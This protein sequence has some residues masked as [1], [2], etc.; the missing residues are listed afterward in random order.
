MTA[1]ELQ[2]HLTEAR[3]LLLA[4]EFGRALPRYEKLTRQHPGDAVLW[5]EYGNAAS[6]LGQ[7]DLADQLWQKALGLA[8]NNAELIGMIGHQYQG[9]RRP[10]KAGACFARAA[11][12][13]PRGINPRISLAVL[14][15]KRHRLDEARAAVNECLAIDS[16]DD[17]ARY[18]SAVLDRR[19]GKVESAETRLRDLIKSSPRHPFVQYACRYELAQ[20][21][22]RN[23]DFDGAMRLLGEAKQIVRGLTDTE[24]LLKGYDKG[25]ESAR[26]FTLSFPKTILRTWAQYFPERKRET[27]A[28]LAFLGGHPRSGTTLLEQVLDS[29]PEVAALDEPT[30]FL[31]VLQPE[32]HKSKELSSARLNT[33]RRLYTAA[34]LR[35]AGPTA[36]G[37]L[38]LDKNPS[39]TARL[40]LWLRV[41]PELRVIIALRDPRDVILSCY[42]QNIALN[43][44]NVNFLSFERLAKH[45]SD[46]MDI[47]LA[48]REWEGFEWLETRY[49]DIVAGLEKEGR[50]VTEFLGLA[51]HDEQAHFY[52]KSRSRQLYSPTYQ[53]V[54]RPVY[55]RSV[56]RWRSYEKYL[57]PILPALEPYCRTFGYC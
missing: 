26:R 22:D 41:F 55:S 18:F 5:A 21:L 49:E 35:E 31:D 33:L 29:H 11:G 1:S 50:R 39:P 8:G 32:F 25:A 46:L 9:M 20:I 16:N 37:K 51:W 47:W 42:F 44:T 27:P 23:N 45:Y 53:D 36:A 7:V 4:R 3:Q 6:G 2:H 17:Q 24:L 12:A 13:D 54:T 38:L 10:E 34:L 52:E 28:R 40:P 14:L 43:A 19:E 57:A 48:V 56:A 30:A 15:E